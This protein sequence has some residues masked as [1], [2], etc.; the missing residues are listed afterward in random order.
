MVSQKLVIDNSV[1]WQIQSVGNLCNEALK[2]DSHI[3]FR[4]KDH[5]IN[6]KSI[7]GVLGACVKYGSEIE[8]VCDGRDEKK[9]LE[10]LLGV[11]KGGRGE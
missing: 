11:L 6:L 4:Y 3:E 10:A 2:Y 9:A 7:L 5:I 8:L 1:N